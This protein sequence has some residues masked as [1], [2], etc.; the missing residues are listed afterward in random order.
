MSRKAISCNLQCTIRHTSLA[1]IRHNLLVTIRHADAPW[2]GIKRRRY[3]IK[4]DSPWDTP[5]GVIWHATQDKIWTVT[6]IL[7]TWISIVNIL[8]LIRSANWIFRLK[9]ANTNCTL[10]AS[11]KENIFIARKFH[12]MS[13][14]FGVLWTE[15]RNV[16]CRL[17]IERTT[18][19]MFSVC[20]QIYVI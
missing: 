3:P 8:H 19:N 1:T 20:F 11:Y 12:S 14:T 4:R 13:S 18:I 15:Y 10:T 9:S 6:W 17:Q 2:Y 5:C 7:R 16:C